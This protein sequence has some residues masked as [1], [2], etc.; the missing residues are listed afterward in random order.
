MRTVLTVTFCVLLATILSDKTVLGQN[1]KVTCSCENVP[2]ST[3]TATVTC[4]TGCSAI[5][6]AG[7]RCAVS[8]RTGL[9]APDLTLD[10][11]QKDGKSIAEELSR[12]TPMQITFEPYSRNVGQLYD[13]HLKGSDIWK[14][15]VFLDKVGNVTVNGLPFQKLRELQKQIKDGEPVVVRLTTMPAQE[16]AEKLSFI[17]GMDIKVISGDP[18]T[19]IS[20]A[21]RRTAFSKILKDIKQKTGVQMAATA[22]KD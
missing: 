3:C 9:L 13:Y 4:S 12:A 2:R 21:T 8:C 22:K 18:A 7:D 17:S 16:V 6:G 1:Q 11:V 15:L 10:F 20:V 5:C 19:P 14:L